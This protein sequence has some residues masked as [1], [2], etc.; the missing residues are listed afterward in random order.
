MNLAWP[1]AHTQPG[2]SPGLDWQAALIK[3]S[4][5][6]PQCRYQGITPELAV[7]SCRQAPDPP[8]FGDLTIPVPAR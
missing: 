1:A 5:V 8:P 7:L 4:R 3:I 2:S 6:K